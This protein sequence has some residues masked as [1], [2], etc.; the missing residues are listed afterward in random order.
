MAP[1]S[2]EGPCTRHHPT[3]KSGHPGPAGGTDPPT[4]WKALPTTHATQ[5]VRAGLSPDG[6]PDG[7]CRGTARADHALALAFGKRAPGRA[8]TTA[9]CPPGP[10]GQQGRRPAHLG[11][12]SPRPLRP[13][14]GAENNYHGGGSLPPHWLPPHQHHLQSRPRSLPAAGQ[15]LQGHG[16]CTR[17]RGQVPFRTDMAPRGWRLK[18]PSCPGSH[19]VGLTESAS[20][21][22][23][24]SSASTHLR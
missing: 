8:K 16:L 20:T 10:G 7:T 22:G 23:P 2:I 6:E 21:S 9:K 14:P 18:L 1:C 24:C 3:N 5:G 11:E 12:S 17:P 13:R 19:L 4:L 15:A